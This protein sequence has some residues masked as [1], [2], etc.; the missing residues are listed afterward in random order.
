MVDRLHGANLHKAQFDYE[1]ELIEEALLEGA[2]YG[3]LLVGY[4]SGTVKEMPKKPDALAVRIA[5]LEAKIK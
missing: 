3:M 1:N 5:H 4:L 2:Y